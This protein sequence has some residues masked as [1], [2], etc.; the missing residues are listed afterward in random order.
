MGLHKTKKLLHNK[1]NGHRIEV[2]ATKWRKS[3]AAIHLI[4]N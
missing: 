2:A 3:V 4:R 1:R